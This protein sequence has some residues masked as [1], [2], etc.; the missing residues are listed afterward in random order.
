MAPAAEAAIRT[1]AIGM[2]LIGLALRALQEALAPEKEIEPYNDY[3]ARVA[4]LRNL[5]KH[6]A[7]F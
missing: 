6:T 7:D 1:S 2:A 4:Q 3:R 5:F